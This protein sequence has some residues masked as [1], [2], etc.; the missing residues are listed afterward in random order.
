MKYEKVRRLLAGA[1]VSTAA[2]S[3]CAQAKDTAEGTEA[4]AVTES[5]SEEAPETESEAEEPLIH[6]IGADTTEVTPLP[7]GKTQTMY[8]D[9]EEVF[10][11][12]KPTADSEVRWVYYLTEE[13][14]VYGTAKG[15]SDE[16]VTWYQVKINNVDYAFI[17]ETYL[18][19]EYP[20][21]WDAEEPAP[22]AVQ[23]SGTGG[24]TGGNAGSV[25]TVTA[26]VVGRRFRGIG[27]EDHSERGVFQIQ[28]VAL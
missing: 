12:E 23:S 6:V 13:V 24:K 18:S 17:R 19:K 20:E 5:E 25:A 21:E 16:T 15:L 3:G 11:Y 7:G 2:L 22:A 27:N 4:L 14:E 28:G 1:L 26:T 9:G 10:A 8:A